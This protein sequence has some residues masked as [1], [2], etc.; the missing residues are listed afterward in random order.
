MNLPQ[1]PTFLSSAEAACI[2]LGARVPITLTS[3]A[4]SAST[5]LASCSLGVRIARAGKAA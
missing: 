3:R 4:D 1:Q 5:R 2:V